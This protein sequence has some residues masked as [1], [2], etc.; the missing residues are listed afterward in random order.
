[1]P[2]PTVPTTPTLLGEVPGTRKAGEDEAGNR[3]YTLVFEVWSPRE[4]GAR[5]VAAVIPFVRGDYYHIGNP[6]DPWEESDTG[7]L[8]LGIQPEQQGDPT[9][10]VVPVHF[11]APSLVAGDSAW[12]A[13]DNPALAPASISWDG[14]EY[15]EIADRDTSGNPVVNK[16]KDPFVPAPTRPRSRGILRVEQIMTLAEWD[17]SFIDLVQNTTNNATFYGRAAGKW[18]CKRV[19]PKLTWN[20]NIGACIHLSGEFHLRPEGWHFRP[21]NDGTRQL[22]YT[23]AHPEGEYKPILVGGQQVSDPKPLDSLGGALAADGTPIFLD[24]ELIDPSD[25]SVLGIRF[26]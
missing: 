11:G 23:Q 1:M 19:I 26:P 5:A 4:Y 12:V 10:W 13:Y 9:K 24:F 15:E 14:E 3:T 21:L 16:A 18:L 6:G 7:S 2:C 25:F 17:D 20:T 8:C 22:V